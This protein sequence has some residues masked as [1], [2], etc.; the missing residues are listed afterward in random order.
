M[1]QTPLNLQYVSFAVMKLSCAGFVTHSLLTNQGAS[2]LLTWSLIFFYVTIGASMRKSRSLHCQG[3]RQL[4]KCINTVTEEKPG[5]HSISQSDSMLSWRWNRRRRRKALS[6]SALRRRRRATM[7]LYYRKVT[8]W[9]LRTVSK[10]PS[11]G[12]Q[13]RCATARFV[14]SS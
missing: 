8:L 10:R 12:F 1:A 7:N 5:S 9:H 13:P 3:P 11:T 14:P 2:L 4:S 6:S